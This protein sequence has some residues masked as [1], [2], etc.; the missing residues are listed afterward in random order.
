VRETGRA[1]PL[2]AA[3][4]LEGRVRT[5]RRLR[6]LE[7]VHVGMAVESQ[8]LDDRTDGER[9]DCEQADSHRDSPGCGGMNGRAA[10]HA[11]RECHTATTTR[12][13]PRP[14]Q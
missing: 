5:R 14:Q 8:G 2:A 9:G 1:E 4:V 7:V 6:G 13:A 11:R 12:D 10:A 3:A